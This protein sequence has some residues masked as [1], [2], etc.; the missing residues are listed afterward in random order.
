MCIVR[1]PKPS[2]PTFEAETTPP[3]G[4]EMSAIWPTASVSL[5]KASGSTEPAGRVVID[6]IEGITTVRTGISR[7]ATTT[8]RIGTTVA[9]LFTV[10]R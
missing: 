2:R 7:A 8:V 4:I 5:V 9:A 3:D 1:P 6:N 10:V